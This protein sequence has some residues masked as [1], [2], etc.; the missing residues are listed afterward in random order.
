MLTFS[1][2]ER[3]SKGANIKLLKSPVLTL[4]AWRGFVF[5]KKSESKK[6]SFIEGIVYLF[7]ETCHTDSV[8]LM[9]SYIIQTFLIL[10]TSVEDQW[11][12]PNIFSL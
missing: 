11:I 6:P 12:A 10:V 2:F 1:P 7:R 8:R 4:L 5:V 3:L 9:F